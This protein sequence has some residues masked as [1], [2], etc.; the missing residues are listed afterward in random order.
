MHDGG[1]L[2]IAD[3]LVGDPSV[4]IPL[5]LT[6]RKIP[7]PTHRKKVRNIIRGNASA[8]IRVVGVLQPRRPSGTVLYVEPAA[9]AHVNGLRPSVGQQVLKALGKAVF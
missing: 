5:A 1:H 8:R 9:A 4:E 7:N 6:E 2:P 3:D